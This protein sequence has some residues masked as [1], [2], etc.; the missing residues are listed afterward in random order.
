MCMVN[1]LRRARLFHRQCR[2]QCEE[3]RAGLSEITRPQHICLSIN[4]HETS[5]GHESVLRYP[6]VLAGPAKNTEGKPWDPYQEY[7]EA[8]AGANAGKKKR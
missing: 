4:M 3:F 6:P 7:I 1:E 2:T 5:N 8:Q